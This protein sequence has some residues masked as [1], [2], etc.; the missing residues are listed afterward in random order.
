MHA[1]GITNT[2]T[3]VLHKTSIGAIVSVFPNPVNNDLQVLIANKPPTLISMYNLQGQ[4]I[5]SLKETSFIDV[6][7]I[8]PGIYFLDA[9]RQ[10]VKFIKQ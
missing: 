8:E 2:S 3:G 4:L 6:S 5:L 1:F 7:R 10:K 9:D